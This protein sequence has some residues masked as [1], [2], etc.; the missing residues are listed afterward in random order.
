MKNPGTV[1]GS[2][3]GVILFPTEEASFGKKAKASL[4]TH[5]FDE[6]TVKMPKEKAYRGQTAQIERDGRAMT[7]PV[8]CKEGR[9]IRNFAC[10][11][12]DSCLDKA[13]KGM[14]SGFTCRECPCHFQREEEKSS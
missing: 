13:A 14:W 6:E 4:E 2:A 12:Y 9:G 7:N 11:F 5:G 10:Q 1:R 8:M 3:L